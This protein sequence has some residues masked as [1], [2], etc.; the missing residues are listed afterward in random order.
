M[1]TRP[2]VPSCRGTRPSQAANSRPDLKAE[3]SPIA[4]TTAVAVSTPT[5]GISATRLLSALP[6]C[7]TPIRCSI[8]AISWSSRPTR[9]HCSRSVSITIAGR[10]LAIRSRASA[11]PRRIPAR[12]RGITS[13]YSVRRPRSP[14]I[15]AV[16][17]FTSC[18][19]IWC[20]ARIACCSSL[21]TATVRTPG[22][23]AAVQI[24]CA[25]CASFLL[26]DTK[27]RTAL[28]GNSRGSWPN[29]RSCLAQ[30]CDPPH[31]SIA[32]TH[33]VR[34]A[35]CSRNFARV[36][37]RSTISPVST[38]TQC[39]WNTRFAVSTPTTVLLVFISD[40]PVCP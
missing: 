3:G 8:S 5:P 36:S 15:C 25:S 39:N 37:F 28:A 14:L 29:S 16:R 22:I 6:Q 12:P 17:N 27:G 20:S 13:P 19:R 26:P 33:G 30:C 32:T 35:K 9:A 24:A 1:R 21:F 40:P 34:L 23:C 18:W 10:R 11:M 7:H 2:P 31:A 4:A 38:S